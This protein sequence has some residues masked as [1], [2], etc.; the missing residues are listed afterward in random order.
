MGCGKTVLTAAVIDELLYH[1]SPES[2]PVSFFFVQH[3]I[4]ESLRATT[5]LKSLIRQCLTADNLPKAVEELLQQY[6]E[7]D[8][9]D[10]DEWFL[11]ME[12]LSERSLLHIIIIDGL[13]ECPKSERDF[14]LKGLKGLLLSTRLSVKVFFSSRQEIG[15]ELD[16]SFAPYH[17]KTMSC[18]EVYAD[19][20]N[21]IK[22]SV[23]DKLAIG[24]LSVGDPKLISEIEDALIDGA[25]GM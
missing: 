18:Q 20:A 13:D 14:I 1:R 19:I 6:L 10:V 22:F 2:T 3:D 23:A 15:R 25:R 8:S 17:Q 21:Y 4:L 7:G 9:P 16:K 12:R 24:E 11:I 5:I